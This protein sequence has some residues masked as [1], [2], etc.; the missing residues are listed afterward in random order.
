MSGALELLA[1]RPGTILVGQP[2]GRPLWHYDFEPASEIKD[3]PR[4]FIHPLY[5]LDGDVLTN[6]RPN[7][8]PWHHGVSFTLSSL[9]GVNFWGGP[10]HR[11]EDSYQWREDQG[12]Q[13][14]LEWKEQSPELMVQRLAWINPQAGD[15]VVVTEEREFRTTL[16]T[17]GWSLEW[18][19]RVTNPHDHELVAHNY[20]SLGGLKGSH[21]TGLQ[22]RG[23]RGLLD[24]HGDDAI[25]LRGEQGASELSALHGTAANW[26][27]WHTQSDQSLNRQVIRFESLSGA[28][29]W[30]VRP[31][32]P[33]VAFAPHRED[34]LTFAAGQTREFHHC[35]TIRRA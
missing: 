16:M 31:E 17:D 8:H 26:L 7:D 5:S 35:I 6:W 4:P 2:G 34:P 18:I 30:F 32:N 24:E 25:G 1:S 13:R 27:E 21:Y 12:V 28:I 14:H 33:L 22:F 15:A 19:S 9:D 29:P 3:S 23:A 10:S 11:A 20:H